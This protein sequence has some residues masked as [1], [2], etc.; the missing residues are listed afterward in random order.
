MSELILLLS[1]DLDVQRAF[2]YHE[3]YQEGRG[4]VFLHYLGTAFEQLRHFPREW[5][6]LSPELP[7]VARTPLSLRHLLYH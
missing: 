7:P 5:G 4:T 2:D 3:D 6:E 1:A